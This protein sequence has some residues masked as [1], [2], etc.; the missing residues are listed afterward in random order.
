MG[1]VDTKNPNQVYKLKKALYGLKQAL[2]AL[3]DLLSSFLLSQKFT[4][5]TVN[6]TL[7]VRRE[8]KDILL[9]QI[10]VDDIIFASTKPDLCETFSKIMCSKFQM[11]MMGKLSFFLGLQISQS[12]RG[13][14]LNQSKYA[15]ELIKKYGMETCELADT[16][17]VEKSKLC[18]DPQGKA[19]D[20]TH[21]RGMIGTLMYLTASRP[22]LVFVVCMC[23]QYQA[24]PTEKH[25]HVVKQIFQCLRG[26]IN[27]G[28]WYSKDSCIA[29]TSFADAD[30]AGCQDTR[31]S[32]SGS[33]QLLG[34]RLVSWS[35][36]KQK[37]TAISSTEAEYIALSGCKQQ[38]AAHDD[39]W[40]PFSERV[41][42]SSTNIRLET[43][44]LQKEKTF[45]VV[46]DL[47]KNSTCFKAFTISSDVP[48][49]FMQQLWYSIKKFQGI[50]SYEF[51]LANKKCIV[52]VEVFRTI[53]DICPRVED[54]DITDVPNDDTALTF[55]IDLGYK[56]P[57]YKHTNMFVD[58]MH[59]P[60]RTL[61]A[62][63]N[64]CL[65]RKTTSN[66]KLR[67]SRINLDSP[68]EEQRQRFKRKE[69]ANDSQEIVDVSEESELE[70]EPEPVKKKTSSKRRVKKKV[71]L[72]ADDNIISD[73]HDAALEIV[74]ESVY[75]SAKKKSGG[76][77]SK[78]VVIQDTP[79]APK[80]KPSTSKT[81]LKGAPSLTLEE[82]EAAD[83]MQALKERV[84]DE[85]KDIIEEKVILEWGDEQDSEYS[86]DDN[87]DVD[88]DDKD[89]DADDEGDDHIS[90]TQDADD[91]DVET[92]SDEDDIYKY[93]IRVRK[94]KDEEMINAEVDYS[95]KGDEE[96]TDAA[97]ADAEK[98]SEVKDDPK[99]AKLPPTSSSLSISSGFSDQFLKLS[100]DSSLKIDLSAEALAALKTQVPSIVDNYLR[101]K[102]RDVPKNQTPIVDLE[103]GSEK[104]ASEILQIKREQ[105]KKQQKLKFTIKSN[106]KAAL[107][108]YDLKSALYQSMH[109]NKSFNK[110]PTNYRLYHALMEALIKDENVMDKGFANTVKDH[111]RKHDDAKDDDDEDPPA[112]PNQDK[113]T[114]RRRTKESESSKNPS[115]T[116]ET[117]KGKALS[118]GS[119]TS[120]F[121][122]AKELVEE[123]IAEVVIDDVGDD[124][125]RKD[126]QPQ[127]ASKP[128]TTKTLN[129]D[130]FK[131]PPRPPTPD[132][133]WN[134]HQIQFKR[135]SLAGFP[136]QSVRSSNAIALDS[137]Y[138]LVLITGASQSRQ[139]V[140][141]SLIH[142]ES[143][144]PPTKN[145]FVVDSSRISIVIVNT[146]E[147]HSDVL[148]VSQ[149]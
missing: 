126:N 140:D 127:D 6:P 106:D 76:R 65:S 50:N 84:P 21:Y 20:P 49:I 17:M 144:K 15:L 110:N 122:P 89:D 148:A 23:A 52:N 70:P 29:L 1:F 24:K 30:H 63:I 108:E 19:V 38:V 135:I 134:K 112:G 120:K 146:K 147:H 22:D 32:M 101:S 27:I 13:N 45:Q 54:V 35:S 42:I 64:K 118:K 9:V 16:P 67:K 81:K 77:S 71:T 121:T 132:P 18:E 46:I 66:D 128:K 117:P 136:A 96:V 114:K 98:T 141:T 28:L 62:I 149:G 3:Y 85:E 130:W 125:A 99:K 105:T 2:R 129:P 104:I 123:L 53:L 8:G 4:K 61:A 145:L 7:F 143:R 69:D 44:V 12:P 88:K 41:K 93:K 57:L 33:M 115:S 14:F 103:Q 82:Q 68:Q 25:L 37:S 47:I 5:G 142:I 113:K 91:E 111:K 131:Q 87:D 139:H 60:W 58:H 55:L 124:V 92:K 137:L 83:I 78:S 75:K 107:E 109:A 73:D 39:K 51:L 80:S 102:V 79:S 26:T 116:K 56:G 34:D 74:T 31:K 90:D 94:D 138:L 95:D 10:Y 11:S 133:E 97:K 40:V 72:S 48:K 86:N 36:K 59:Q 43:T 100:S 119:K